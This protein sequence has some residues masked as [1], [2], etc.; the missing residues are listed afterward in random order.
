VKEPNQGKLPAMMLKTLY[1][2]PCNGS[3]MAKGLVSRQA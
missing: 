3:S 1:S 2:S